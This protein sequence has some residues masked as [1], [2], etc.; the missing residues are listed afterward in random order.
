MTAREDRPRSAVE[1]S[2]R[3]T[4]VVVSLIVASL[5]ASVALIVVGLQWSSTAD[6]ARTRTATDESE[7]R[8][9]TARRLSPRAAADSLDLKA[10]HVAEAFKDLGGAI[11]SVAPSLQ[12]VD[13]VFP[14]ALVLYNQGDF[15][16]ARA[17]YSGD[18]ARL[19]Q[20]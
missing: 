7:A 13:Q 17:K 1:R 14:Q 2:R 5:L 10:A 3:R 19:S 16:A 4:I 15:A 18:V 8:Q 11:D 9:F 20:T 12:N 6:R